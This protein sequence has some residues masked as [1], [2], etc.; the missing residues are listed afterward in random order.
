MNSLLQK[1]IGERFK[2]EVHYQSLP[3]LFRRS[4]PRQPA[5]DDVE[6]KDIGLC[7]LFKPEANGDC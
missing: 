4:K 3:N 6:H 1:Y 7:S 5:V 2:R